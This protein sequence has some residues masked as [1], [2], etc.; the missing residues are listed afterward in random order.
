MPLRL[1]EYMTL[2][3]RRKLKAQSTLTQIV[4]LVLYHGQQPWVNTSLSDMME[5]VA[6]LRFKG[7][8]FNFEVLDVSRLSMRRIKGFSSLGIADIA[9]AISVGQ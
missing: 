6:G 4:P 3:W 1:L 2:I 5:Q 8:S 7:L 9:L